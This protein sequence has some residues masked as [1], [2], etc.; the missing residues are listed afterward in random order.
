MNENREKFMNAG[1][2]VTAAEA[3]NRRSELFNKDLDNKQKDFNNLINANK[4]SEIDFSDKH[5]SPIGSEMDDMLA[6]AIAKR[7]RELTL[8]LKD[9]DTNEGNKWIHKDNPSDKHIKIGEKINEKHV[10]FEDDYGTY[11]QKDAEGF[12][13]INALRL[14]LLAVR[15]R[16]TRK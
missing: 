6:Q 8:V 4:P 16:K 15:D 2:P 3:A 9:Q 11:N 5:D 10:T 1:I 14:K 12:I 7:E 13:K